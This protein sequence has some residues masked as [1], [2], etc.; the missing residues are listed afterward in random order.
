MIGFSV[1]LTWL[2]AASQAASGATEA[3]PWIGL[4][5]YAAA[6]VFVIILLTGIYLILL[7]LRQ[8]KKEEMSQH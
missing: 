5:S 7:A 8:R 1:I 6:V 2:P 4:L 3:H